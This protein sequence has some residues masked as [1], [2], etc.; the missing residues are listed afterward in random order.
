MTRDNSAYHEKYGNWAGNP[1]GSRPDL[2]RCCESVTTYEGRW[3]HSHQCRNRRGHGPGE[4]Y[5]RVHDPER[6]E[7]RRQEQ[8]RRY[9]EGYNRDLV[10]WHAGSFKEA[11]EKIAAGHN[12]ARGLAQEVLAKYTAGLRK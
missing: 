4:A 9:N 8:Q 11:L 5:C 1:A 3:P 10:K 2:K 12:D 7:A 6:V